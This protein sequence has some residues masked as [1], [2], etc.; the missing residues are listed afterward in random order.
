MGS[1]AAHCCAICSAHRMPWGRPAHWAER[2]QVSPALASG[3]PSLLATAPLCAAPGSCLPLPHVSV[4]VSV[5]SLLISGLLLSL[6][7]LASLSIPPLVGTTT[8]GRALDEVPGLGEKEGPLGCG[9]HMGSS[10]SAE[11]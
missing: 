1:G 6:L 3:Q 9:W 7:P 8:M 5:S 4:L 10:Q 11:M 2:E